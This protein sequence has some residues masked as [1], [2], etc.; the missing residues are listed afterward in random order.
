M[1][2]ATYHFQWTTSKKVNLSMI[3]NFE[4]TENKTSLMFLRDSKALV[5]IDN[6]DAGIRI[7]DKVWWYEKAEFEIIKTDSRM[8]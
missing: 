7:D 5:S 3:S 2:E 6:N 8:L 4:W 1:K